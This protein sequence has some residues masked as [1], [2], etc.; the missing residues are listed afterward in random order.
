M[1]F[2]TWPVDIKIF[3]ALCIYSALFAYLMPLAY[4]YFGLFL[5]LVLPIGS[6]RIRSVH[7]QMVITFDLG[8]FDATFIARSSRVRCVYCVMY[9]H[10]KT[11]KNLHF[12]IR[13][14]C[15]R[16]NISKTK[17]ISFTSRWFVC[18]CFLRVFHG[19]CLMC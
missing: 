4:Y 8:L 3:F 10:R 2:I 14:V 17:L 16:T 15:C 6:A 19:I 9:I 11:H 13:S 18:I 12:R 5:V 1:S 7:F